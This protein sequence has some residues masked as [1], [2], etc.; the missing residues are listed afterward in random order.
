MS[1][2]VALV[3]F[4]FFPPG[5]ALVLLAGLTVFFA[6]CEITPLRWH[7][8]TSGFVVAGPGVII[9]GATFIQVVAD[10]AQCAR[11]VWRAAQT[12]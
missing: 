3:L 5:R 12:A 7:R 9:A 8:E 11:T 1:A 4:Y 2:A 6:N 10:L